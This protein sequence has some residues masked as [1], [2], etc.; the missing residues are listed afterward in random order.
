MKTFGQRLREVRRRKDITLERLSNDIGVTK[1]TLSRYENDIRVPDVHTAN[2]IAEYLGVSVDYL[3]GHTI[4]ENVVR[5]DNCEKGK[6]MMDYIY[7]VLVDTDQI[8]PEE[9]AHGIEDD[10]RRKEIFRK[11]GTAIE[12]AKNFNK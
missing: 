10:E 11:I 1:A 2:K 4:S 3:L 8:T 12:F 9:A 7:K 5:V 6:E